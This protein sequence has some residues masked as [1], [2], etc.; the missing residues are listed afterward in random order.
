MALD[1]TRSRDLPYSKLE[2]LYIGITWAG[3][4]TLLT[5]LSARVA[6][7]LPPDGVP[8]TLQTLAV[9][10]AALCLGP[11]WGT[12]SMLMYV[13]VGIIGG[14]VFAGGTAGWERI[15]GQTGGYLI[16]YPICQPIIAMIVRRTKPDGSWEARGW[17]ALVLAV[18]VGHLVIFLIGVP[19]LAIARGFTLGRALEGG[20]YP[21]IPGMF[22]KCVLAVMIGRFAVPHAMK[23]LW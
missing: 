12:A 10:L 23:K 8:M 20:F 17:G 2:R 15:I 14:G 3:I 19:W 1:L 13:V 6:I 9:V 5:G 16:A 21:F 18:L 4:F 22:V 11:K 7:P